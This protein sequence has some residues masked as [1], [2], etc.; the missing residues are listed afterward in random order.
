MS[1][2]RKAARGIGF[3]LVM[4]L[5]ANCTGYLTRLVMARNLSTVEYGL[6]YAAFSLFVIISLLKHLG[7]GAALI[8]YV[9]EHKARDEHNA[10]KT[11]ILSVLAVQFLNGVIL[12]A[13]LYLASGFL[14]KHYFKTPLALD[15]LHVF[16]LFLI[17]DTFF[18]VFHCVIH[19]FQKFGVIAWVEFARNFIVLMVVLTGFS[20]GFRTASFPVYGYIIAGSILSM[21]LLSFILREFDLFKH[22]IEDFSGTTRRIFR[23]G[24]PLT[25]AVFG[26]LII[27]HSDVLLLTYFRP[28]AEVGIYNVVLP[29]AMVF[30]HL[31]QAVSCVVFPMA[32]ELWT[33][34]DKKR[35]SDGLRLL[36][37]YAFAFILPFIFSVFAFSTWFLH[38]FFGQQFVPGALALKILLVGTL[39]YTVAQMN[40][41]ILTGVGRQKTVAK[42]ILF[43]ALVNIIANLLLIPR[44]GMEGAAAATSLS[45]IVAL[46]LSTRKITS[47][48][49]IEFPLVTWL[50]LVVSGLVFI[51]A[52]TGIKSVLDINPWL[53]LFVSTGLS[54]LAYLLVLYYFKVLDIQEL[55]K[56]FKLAI[57]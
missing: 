29:S 34:D 12:G 10:I 55:K 51:A 43:A 25:L 15:V 45:Y 19:G 36:H 1:Y 18:T 32:S 48:V 13:G 41:S 31:S 23:F 49:K 53:E 52:V 46:W 22:R 26:G 11:S 57:N 47:I 37:K 44:F 30:L 54:L 21:V 14:S 16:V 42:F 35:L 20:I 7:L 3:I 17:V 2:T 38:L 6:F 33:S 24:L 4:K 5:L 56:Y 8:K 9:A 28:L 40:C 50:K 27:G 39:C